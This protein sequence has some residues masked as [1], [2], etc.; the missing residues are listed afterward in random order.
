MKQNKQ[1]V[2]LNE[3]QLRQV[4]KESIKKILN[5]DINEVSW[6]T[7]ANARDRR[8]DFV[9]KYHDSVR[10]YGLDNNPNLSQHGKDLY[11]KSIDRG[12]RDAGIALEKL[13]DEI[14]RDYPDLVAEKGQ[15]IP[16]KSGIRNTT[17]IY[18]MDKNNKQF[19]VNIYGAGNDTIE[20]VTFDKE[21]IMRDCSLP[22][23]EYVKNNIPQLY[24][25][26]YKIQDEID[27]WR[28]SM[29]Y[30]PIYRF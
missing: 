14:I 29:G 16:D 6:Q 3:N 23:L 1:I 21:G 27:D 10:E 13:V 15:G 9:N 2:K 4:I 5:E 26:Y 28:E 18:V 17:V 12:R 7:A 24:Y 30:K 19:E 8:F 25:F 20:M 22:E 11:R